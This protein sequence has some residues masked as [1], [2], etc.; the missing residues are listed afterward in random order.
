MKVILTGGSGKVGKYLLS[1]LLGKHD[2][3]VY[4]LN[5]PNNSEMK[6]VRGDVTILQN[7]LEA[8][9]G[10]DAII[11]LAAVTSPLR[12]PPEK[13]FGVNMMGTFCVLEAAVKCGVKKVVVASSDSSLGFVYREKPL[14]PEYLPIDENH[15]LKPQDPYGLSKLIGE[16]ICRRYSMA[17]GIQTICLRLCLVWFPDNAEYF[18]SLIETNALMKGLWAYVDAR[19]AAQAFRLALEKEDVSHDIFFISAE[20]TASREE[21]SQLIQRYYPQVPGVSRRLTGRKSLIDCSKAR[22]VLGYRPRHS[23]KEFERVK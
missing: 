21:T 16:E 12:D 6:F 22:R 9:Q 8:F 1:E 4:D 13:V 20:D 23:W 7:C 14:K 10:A 17:Y 3:T 19:D 2:V 11:H 18:L 5:K 15:P